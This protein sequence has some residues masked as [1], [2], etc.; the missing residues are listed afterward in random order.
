M[1]P[2]KEM[3]RMDVNVDEEKGSRSVYVPQLGGT[4]KFE[5]G[6]VLPV[7]YTAHTHS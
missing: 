5:K 7:Y 1:Y 6:S 3:M 4:F 2:L